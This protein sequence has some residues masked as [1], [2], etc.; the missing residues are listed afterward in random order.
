MSLQNYISESILATELGLTIRT[1][2][3]LRAM[4][5]GPPFTQLGRKIVYRREAVEAWLR[6]R[7]VVPQSTRRRR[8]GS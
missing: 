8:S 6:S 7:E 4:R 3:R 2:A 1:L 5:T